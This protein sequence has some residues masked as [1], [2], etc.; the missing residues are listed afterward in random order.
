MDAGSHARI[1][2]RREAAARNQAVPGGL[3]RRGE[4]DR[5]LP[6][7][8]DRTREKARNRNHA[9]LQSQEGAAGVLSVRV[10]ADGG[11]PGDGQ[12]ESR[13]HPGRQDAA[14]S[15]DRQLHGTEFRHGDQHHRDGSGTQGAGAA[16]DRGVCRTHEQAAIAGEAGD[17]KMNI[18]SVRNAFMLLSLLAGALTQASAQTGAEDTRNAITGLQV[19]QQAG[20]VVVKIS[21]KNPLTSAPLTFSVANPPRIAFDFQGTDNALGRSAQEVREGDLRSLNIVQ[22]GDRTRLVLNLQKM[23][24]AETRIEKN[25][26][27]I[28]LSPSGTAT[29]P[30]SASAQRFAEAA[31]SDEAKAIRNIAF[32]RGKDG[33]GRIVVDLSS[34]DTG[35]DLR[36]QGSNLVVVFN[37]VAL[38]DNLRQRLDV[39]DFGTPVTT[40]DTTTQGNNVHMTIGASGLWEHNAYQSDNQF[41]VEIKKIIENPNKLVQ[42]SRGGYQG[43]KLSLNFQ[44][45]DVRAVLQVIADFT[46][47]NIITSDTVSGNLTLR[48]KD[49]PWDQALDIILQAKGL[50]MRKNGNVIWIAPRDELAARE[51][52]QLE[53]RAQIGDLEPMQT[54]SFQINYHKAKEIF[55]F[56][57]SKHQT[58]LSKC[59]SVISDDRSNKIFVTDVAARLV[60]LRK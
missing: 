52:L 46:N 55:D 17:E 38:P 2:G 7:F 22:V 27:F 47:F 8:Q 44:N 49:V 24:S 11:H 45:V 40:V 31:T 16:P 42:G 53:S 26:M 12:D 1:E 58:M 21:L 20:N 57:K 36:Q 14:S 56:L 29:E 3:L 5:S 54:E 6:A 30:A 28:T 25:E 35:I 39:T 60:D 9:G 59:G 18:R 13:R 4:S 51:K 19:A 33:E 23:A 50:D 34:R 10:A 37:N 43:E 41:V 15:E 32:R 48:L